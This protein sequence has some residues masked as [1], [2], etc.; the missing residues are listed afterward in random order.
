M[1][2]GEKIQHPKSYWK[3]TDI[4]I[5]PLKMGTNIQFEVLPCGGSLRFNKLKLMA[6]TRTGE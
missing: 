1:V 4:E 2:F 3:I 6:F 5:N